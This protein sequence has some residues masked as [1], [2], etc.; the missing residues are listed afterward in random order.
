LIALAV[1][2]ADALERDAEGWTILEPSAD[3]RVIYVSSSE[4][5]DSYDGLS[6]DR[7]K[8]TPSAD[9]VRNLEPDWM[10]LKRG[11][12]WE[13]GLWF[14]R[15]G[16]TPDA[17]VVLGDYGDPED[18]RP[19]LGGATIPGGRKNVVV[20]GIEFSDGVSMSGNN[21]DVLFEDCLFKGISA[22]DYSGPSQ[23]I[24]IYR[25]QAIDNAPESGHTQGMYCS[26]V[27]GLE[28]LEC[29]ID[30]NGHTP[31]RDRADA[32]IYNH[33][34]YAQSDSRNVN[35][36]DSIIARASSHGA[37]LRGG[38]V[39]EG[40]V[41]TRNPVSMSF[42]FIL[43]PTD[44]AEGGVTGRI[45]NNVILHGNDI[46]DSNPR[47]WLMELG[48]LNPNEQM[49]VRDNIAAHFASSGSGQGFKL[50]GNNEGSKNLLLENNIVYDWPRCILAETS[51]VAFDGSVI[52]RNNTFQLPTIDEYVIYYSSDRNPANHVYTDN[53]LHAG[54]GSSDAFRVDNNNLSLD[55]WR[56][57]SGDD[58]SAW[59]QVQYVDPDRDLASYHG[60]I[61]K[62]ATFEAFM[63]EARKQSRDNWR[64]EYTAKA[65]REYIQAGFRRVDEMSSDGVFGGTATSPA[66]ATS[67]PVA[68]SYSGA[69]AP[70]GGD[71]TVHLWARQGADGEW[72]NTGLTAAGASGT[73]DY[74]E[75]PDDGI[76]YFAVQG[77]SNGVLSPAPAGPGDSATMY[78]T[79]APVPGMAESPDYEKGE[80]VEIQ[81]AGAYDHGSGLDEVRL[82]VRKND[83]A[84]TD[85]GMRSDAPNGTFAFTPEGDAV[86]HF[87][88]QAK[89]RAG[90][91]SP[92]PEAEG[93]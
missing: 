71:V 47:G 19:V 86:Y 73:F 83:E 40:N 69:T 67:A 41:F 52:I 54:D 66:A 6:P 61:G 1:F 32:T 39:I 26:G 25:C 35:L 22:I 56:S 85:T 24:T 12:A 23:D 27:D 93:K 63:A 21:R 53:V 87:F 72:K 50:A 18:P 34:L 38:G 70:D 28:I 17:P 68:V 88:T 77:E 80:Q 9:H 15:S 7:P 62:E 75:L 79:A 43:G 31:G 76:Y 48:N 74:A 42:G 4:G 14:G 82:W 45:N 37:Q 29:L 33:N 49:V 46:D 11:D 59:Q 91:V 3:S 55:E 58:S 2:P 89:D 44:P 57:V 81:F 10:L 36:R 30:H 60:F 5:N 64:P 16:P 65:V 20:V 84:W 51:A 78:D 90:N 13:E 92:T 8:K